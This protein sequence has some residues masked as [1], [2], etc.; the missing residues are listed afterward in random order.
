MN[1]KYGALSSSVNPQELSLTVESIGKTVG[2]LLVLLASVKGVNPA[3]V[4][5]WYEPLMAQATVVIS[6]AYASYNAIL[7][8]WGLFRKG[9]AFLYR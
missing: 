2:A 5:A 1:R 7:L 3:E 4:N 6:S 9:I 8:F